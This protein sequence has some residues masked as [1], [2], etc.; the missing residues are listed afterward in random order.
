MLETYNS[1]NTYHVHNLTFEMFVFL[2][3]LVEN[4]IK[5]KMIFAN[6]TIYFAEIEYKRKKIKL[7]RSYKL[8]MLSLK[9]LS[10]MT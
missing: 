9:K 3:D 5:F 1:K 7:R 10:E 8:T 6:K 2:K 4:K